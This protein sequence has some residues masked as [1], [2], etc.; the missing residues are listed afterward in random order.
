[1]VLNT[2]FSGEAKVRYA[3]YLQHL[4][5]R[6]QQREEVGERSTLRTSSMHGLPQENRE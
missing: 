5:E 6:L 3:I 2:N 1:M 4:Q